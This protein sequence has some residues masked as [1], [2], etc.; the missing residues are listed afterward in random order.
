MTDDRRPGMQV[1]NVYAGVLQSSAKNLHERDQELARTLLTAVPSAR[2]LAQHNRAFVLAAA[3]AAVRQHGITQI[4]DLGA[5]R[6]MERNVHDVAQA[7]DTVNVAYVDHSPEVVAHLEE[8]GAGAG[9]GSLGYLVADIRDPQLVLESS[10]VRETIDFTCPVAV[11]L[12][13]VVPYITDVDIPALLTEYTAALTPGSLVVLSHGTYDF[14]HTKVQTMQDVYQKFGIPSHMRSRDEL[15]ALMDQAGVT[16][17][18]P[19]IVATNQWHPGG[20]SRDADPSEACMY[21]LWGRIG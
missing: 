12:A 8:H 16:V 4:L 3:E 21:G 18:P 11:L 14:A 2:L 15:H 5:G 13:A 7:V 17:L 9:R 19:G 1:P 20:H 10:V 6:P